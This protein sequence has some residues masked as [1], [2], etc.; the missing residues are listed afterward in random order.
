MNIKSIF[1]RIIA[2]LF[3][4]LSRFTQIL[5]RRLRF[6]KLIFRFFGKLIFRLF[7]FPVYKLFYWI[8]YK[9]LNI[10]TPVKSKF[11]YVL[12][13]SYFIHIVIVVISF[14]VVV[15]NINAEEIRQ[16]DFGQKTIVYSII[17]KEEYEELTEQTQVAAYK[18]QTTSYLDL[19]ASVGREIS[20]IDPD[21]AIE[22]QMVTEITTVTEGGSAV[23]KP[24]IMKPIDVSDLPEVKTPGRIGVTKYVVKQGETISAIADKFKVSVETLLWQND[25]GPRS[26]IRPGDELEILP[27][28]GVSHKIAR[29]E[30]LGGI[31]KKYNVTVDD[32]VKYNNLF[33]VSDIQI[34]QKLVI[35]G[36]KK[37]SPY[38]T[39]YASKSTPKVGSISKLFASSP[40]QNATVSTSGFLWP[41]SVRRISQYY[42]WRH[43]GLDIAG[44]TGTPL[45]ASESGTIE[46]SGW[47][48]GYGYNVL[49]NHG[50]GYKTRYAHASKLYVSSGDSVAKGQNIAAMGSTGW[51]TGP[52][53]HYEVILNGVKKNPLSYIK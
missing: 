16:E 23:V 25:L 4:W 40:Q 46:Y 49:I 33:D 1:V 43:T 18:K 38:V 30:T 36:G 27:V 3:R 20:T 14:G 52:H 28:S 51:S 22:D 53:I 9:A 48:N 10:Y 29:G 32:V 2:G 44:P 17:A 5:I 31:A 47:S 39:R 26:L 19:S 12:N 24:D 50:N 37:S 35:P 41:T 45:Y 7:I 21:F 42:S 34:G 15:D 8:K 13:K 6:F 11:F